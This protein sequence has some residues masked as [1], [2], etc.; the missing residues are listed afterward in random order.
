MN[1]R[2]AAKAASM[3]IS[4][5]ERIVALN[6]ADIVDYNKCIMDMIAGESPC[7]YCEDWEECNRETK[8]GKGCDLWMLRWQK[9]GDLNGR[10]EG[11]AEETSGADDPLLRLEQPG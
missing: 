10:E 9:A 3:R 5:L 4:E 6:K 1:A 7:L 11:N 2:Q 8:A